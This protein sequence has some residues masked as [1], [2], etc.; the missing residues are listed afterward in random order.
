MPRIKRPALSEEQCSRY[1]KEAKKHK[2][3]VATLKREKNITYEQA[4]NVMRKGDSGKLQTSRTKTKTHNVDEVIE[5]L[6]FHEIIEHQLHYAAAQLHT[7]KAMCHN[8][9]IQL[10]NKLVGTKAVAQK[11]SIESHIK[12]TDAEIIAS[13]VRRYEPDASDE[14]IILVYKEELEKWKQSLVQ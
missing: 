10:L 1:Y 7:D 12:T 4:R 14:R 8:D 6:T 11:M 3:S 13:I 5:T 9:K 2:W